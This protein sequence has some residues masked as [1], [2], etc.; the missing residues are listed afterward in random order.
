MHTTDL[1]ARENASHV[2]DLRHSWQAL[3]SCPFSF[4][5]HANGLFSPFLRH[6]MLGFDS[7]RIRQLALPMA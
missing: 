3:L 5:L 6:S 2:S 4:A 7:V 1:H